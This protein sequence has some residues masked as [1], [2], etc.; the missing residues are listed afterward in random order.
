MPELTKDLAPVR[1]NQLQFNIDSDFTEA[2]DAITQVCTE[3]ITTFPQ[4]LDLSNV[5]NTLV[6]ENPLP[7]ASSNYT[8]TSAFSTIL[9][10][11][12]LTSLVISD[13]LL[14]VY[15]AE[16]QTILTTVPFQVCHVSSYHL[17]F[18]FLDQCIDHWFD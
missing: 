14:V 9:F 4:I 7:C 16:P 18:L 15:Y 11:P 5:V 17:N 2:P 6:V 10:Q 12:K 8:V 3:I 13:S 1:F